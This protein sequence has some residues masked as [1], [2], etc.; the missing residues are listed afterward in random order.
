MFG[1]IAASAP[2]TLSA[3]LVISSRWALKFLRHSKR[4]P[5]YFTTLVVIMWIPRVCRAMTFSTL[6]PVKKMAPVFSAASV[7]PVSLNH[8]TTLGMTP[9]II[10]F[11][12]GRSLA[13]NR[14]A[15]SSAYAIALSNLDV[16]ISAKIPSY[17]MFHRNGLSTEPCGTLA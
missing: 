1:K 17:T 3:L 5:R 16:L 8:L 13:E 2:D 9:A 4:I 7:S 12:C 14:I 11:S 15:R 6:R 10:S